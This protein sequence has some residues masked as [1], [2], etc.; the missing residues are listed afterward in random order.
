VEE[1]GGTQIAVDAAP[2]DPAALK[3]ELG[4]EEAGLTDEEIK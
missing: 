2:F 1:L 3:Q 4:I